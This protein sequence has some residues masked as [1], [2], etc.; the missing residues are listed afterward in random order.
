M[1]KNKFIEQ[2]VNSIRLTQNLTWV[3]RTYNAMVRF[4]KYVVILNFFSLSS[5]IWLYN[6]I[7]SQTLSF[8]LGIQYSILSKDIGIWEYETNFPSHL[9]WYVTN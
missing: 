7:C 1:Q 2:I 5:N 9:I 6:K 4:S 3:L 8:Y